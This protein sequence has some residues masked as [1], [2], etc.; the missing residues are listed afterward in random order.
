MKI[1]ETSGRKAWKTDEV[2]A[3]LEQRG[4]SSAD[5]VMPKVERIVRDVRRGGDRMLRRYAA[6]LD[7]LRQDQPLR[8]PR[9]AMTGALQAMPAEV[10]SA[11]ELAAANITT[12]AKRQLPQEFQ[13]ELATGV[14]AGQRIRPLGSVGCYVPS[15]RYPLPSTLLMTAIPARVAGVQRI[16]VVSPRPSR[17][18]L[19]V[20][21]MLGIEEFYAIG[22]A[23]AIA[24]LAYGTNDMQRV[25]KIVGPGNQYVTAAKRLV[26][27]DCGIDMLAGP[28]EIGIT[29]ENGDPSFIASDIVAQSEHD[30]E[31]VAVF[32]TTNAKLAK[33]VSK[34][35]KKRAK[36]NP[37]AAISLAKNGYIFIAGSVEEAQSITNRLA[38]EHL[39]VDA[40]EDLQWVTSAGSVFIGKW[41]A[42]AF[43]DYISGPN[44]T[45]PT[46][47]LAH[48]RGGLSV[49]DYV[50]IITV[51]RYTSSGVE[52]LGRA[53]V[54]LA[55]CEGLSGHSE[56]VRTRLAAAGAR[57]G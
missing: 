44:H 53:A 15:G 34:E 19:A 52:S 28:T 41:S 50:K 46:G 39:S 8:V 42:Q 18:T 45:L 55:E 26:S 12:F 25:D 20:A 56:A 27:H 57:H 31:A 7:G 38:F 13:L 51:Q 5:R 37:T 40:E 17:E 30:P 54:T 48:I 11:L 22:G 1:F 9:E 49:L 10:R 2:L 23:H 16:V 6:K 29:S 43:G 21:S 36:S 33:A 47:G 14:S 4:R 35:T 32:I 3:R 24:A